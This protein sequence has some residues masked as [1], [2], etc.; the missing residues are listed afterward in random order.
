MANSN[1]EYGCG[2]FPWFL[3]LSQG[4]LDMVYSFLAIRLQENKKNVIYSVW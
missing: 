1:L 2:K 4:F 3:S